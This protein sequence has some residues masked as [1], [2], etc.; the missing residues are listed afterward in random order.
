MLQD[1][2]LNIRHIP[3]KRNPTDS[4]SR[5][6]IKYILV[7]KGP[8][9]DASGAYVRQLRIPEEATVTDIQEALNRI[10]DKI[11]ISNQGPGSVIGIKHEFKTQLQFNT[12]PTSMFKDKNKSI[13]QFY[14]CFPRGCS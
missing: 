13:K 12:R 7:R 3:G 8:V 9:H 14:Q 4:L 6:S 1:Y 2:N 5:Q 11:N 10:F